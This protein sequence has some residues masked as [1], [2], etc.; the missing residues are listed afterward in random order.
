MILTDPCK[1]S[2]EIEE[3]VLV[4]LIHRLKNRALRIVTFKCKQVTKLELKAET[5]CVAITSKTDFLK[6]AYK[7]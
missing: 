4:P 2:C 6:L 3:H 5:R 7:T 1:R